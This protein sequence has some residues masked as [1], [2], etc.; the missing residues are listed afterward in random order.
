VSAVFP[1]VAVCRFPY[2]HGLMPLTLEQAQR[3][4]SAAIHKANGLGVKV[5]VAVCDL[6]G[7]LV[8]FQR[9]D[10]AIAAGGFGAQ[11]KARAS[12]LFGRPSSALQERADT[13]IIR[14]IIQADGGQAIASKGAVPLMRQGELVGAIGVGGATPDQDELCAEAGAAA[15]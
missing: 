12:V 9:M 11:G 5:C 8:A 10:G 2:E 4:A 3:A 13:P 6:G 7:R 14:G 15:I 1:E